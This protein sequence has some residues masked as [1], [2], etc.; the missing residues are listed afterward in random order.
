MNTRAHVTIE[1]EKNGAL[2][3]FEMPLG[4]PY[5]DAHAAALEAAEGVVAMSKQSEEQA[6]AQAE[7]QQA[8]CENACADPV[9]TEV[10]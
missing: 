10:V 4:V 2:F 8:P 6:K 5:V 1:I 9:T 3:R 7:A